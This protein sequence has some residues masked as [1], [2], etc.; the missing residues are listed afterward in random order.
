MKTIIFRVDGN[1]V[2]G[3]GHI[4]RCLSI[5]EQ[6]K[7]RAN[8]IF[9][10]ADTSVNDFILSRG[11]ENIC[12]N[13]VWDDMEGELEN[14]KKVIE[15]TRAEVVLVD[16]YY[17]SENY[18]RSIKQWTKIYYIDDVN[19]FKYP[20]DGLINYNI[21]GENLG[22]SKDDYKE[23]YLGTK[24]AP[25]RDEFGG[26]SGREF[27]E[28]RNI[29]ITSGGTDKYNVIG[30][31]LDMMSKRADFAA[32]EYYCILGKFNVNVESLNVKYGL[33]ENVHLLSNVNNMS[34]YMN[35]CDVA[36]TA[37]GSTCYEMC[38]CGIPS[39]VYTLA[40]N[41]LDGAK[42]FSDKGIIPWVGDVRE[43]IDDS[44]GNIEREIDELKSKDTWEARSKLMQQVVDGKGAE[45]LAD[46]LLGN[47]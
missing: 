16:S 35:L 2:I 28:L 15:D 22:Y 23:L 41:Q 26:I 46:V 1:Q 42:T 18:L 13:S 27:H 33:L 29:L 39:V 4:M 34:Y 37:G 43:K 14:F 3:T 21:Y 44:M 8:I 7:N 32:Y 6:L 17:V 25:L 38:A 5:A 24:Y 19:A 20:V 11:F 47:E 9:V 30:N 45:R 36:I 40:D 10:T 31:V 12:L